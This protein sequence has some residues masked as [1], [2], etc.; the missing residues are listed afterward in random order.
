[1]SPFITFRDKDD[2]GN[3]QYYILQRGFPHYCAR[4]STN[5]YEDALLKQPI[6]KYNMYVVLT[7]TILGSVVPSYKDTLQEIE[8]KLSTMAVWFYTDRIVGDEKRFKK[9]KIK[10][11]ATINAE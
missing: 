10:T 4:I 7:G 1:M 11:D 5:P 3:L 6:S 9:F 2:L 8:S